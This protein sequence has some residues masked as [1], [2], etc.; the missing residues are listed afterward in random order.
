MLGATAGLS[1][2]AAPLVVRTAGQAGGGTLLVDKYRAASAAFDESRFQRI[3]GPLLAGAAGR[4]AIDDRVE[5]AIGWRLAAGGRS[6]N[7]SSPKC[8]RR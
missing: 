4:Q 1:S 3:A 7:S 8:I 5:S 2:R 6:G